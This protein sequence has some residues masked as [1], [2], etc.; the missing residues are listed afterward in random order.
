MLTDPRV[1]KLADLLVNH[2]VRTGKGDH[3]LIETFDCPDFVAAAVAEQVQ[4]SSGHAHV[5]QRSTRVMRTLNLGGEDA[6]KV[7]GEYDLER[8]KRMQCYIGIRGADN[9]SEMS[10]MPE[11]QMKAVGRLYAKP[12]HFD[13]RINHTRWC[14]LRWPSPSMAQLAQSST[15]AFEDFYFRVCTLDYARMDAAAR[16]LVERMKRTDQV[17]IKGPGATDLRFSIKGIGVV[18]CCGDRNIPDGEVFTAPVRDSVEGVLQYNTPTLHNGNTFTNIR[19]EFKK[20]RIVKTGC[21]GGDPKL[22]ES[23]FDTDEGA[24]HIGEFAIGFHPHIREA[25]KDILFDEK[26]AGSFHFT[27]GRCYE[28]TENGNRSEIHWDLVCIQRPEYGG[29]TISFD[30]EVIRKDGIF[31]AKELEGLNPDRLGAL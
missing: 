14:V 22:L 29:G 16:P 7:W 15:E 20:G 28:E 18:P 25:M 10:G 12:V 26:I 9:A 8:M 13:R 21:D 2:S 24:R 11:A 30:G 6:L 19:L 5:V 4:K 23:I 3:V 31:V 1:R 17:H 27:P